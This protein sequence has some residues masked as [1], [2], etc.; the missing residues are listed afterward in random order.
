MATAEA[1]VNVNTNL[2]KQDLSNL[3]IS[4][5]TPLSPEVI[6]RQ[7]TIN[8]G[9]IGHVAHGK[10]TVVKAIS[11]VQTVRFKNELERNITIKLERLSE[12]KIQKLLKSKQ[13]RDAYDLKQRQQLKQ[14]IKRRRQASKSRQQENV[15]AP[16][17][18]TRRSIS[19]VSLSPSHSS[20]YGSVIGPDEHDTLP[21]AIN[22]D[23]NSTVNRRKRCRSSND[24]Q[25][26]HSSSPALK[27]PKKTPK[28][29]YFVEVIERVEVMHNEP[30][31]YVKW[32]GYDNSENT[33]ETFENLADCVQLEDFVDRQ[34]QLYEPYIKK[35]TS[36]LEAELVT[37]TPLD[38]NSINIEKDLDNYESMP[39]SLDLILLA[40]Y[41]AAGSRSQRE[42]QRI[43]ERALRRIQ[44]QRCYYARRKQ[45]QELALFERRMN[46]VEHPA[47]PITV[48]N[49]VDLDSIDANFVYI[50]KNI[51]SDSVPHPEEAVFG[52]NCK[53]DEGDGKTECCATSRC[54]A[55][56][57]GELYAYERTT[58]RLRLPQGSA[59]FECNSRCSCDDSCTNRLVQFGRKHPLELF[60]TSNGRGWGVRT[61]NSLRKGEFVCEYVG[62]IIS[63]DEANE[64]GKAYDDK[65]RTYLFDLDYNTAAESEFTID[66]ANY[67]NV[68]H[69][70]NHS[71]DPNLAVFPCWIEH[72]NMAL[73]HLVFFT[74]RY[75]KAGEE[76]S[77]DYIRADNEAVPYENLS[78]AARVECRCGAPNCRKVLF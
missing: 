17:T 11:G 52:C 51:L 39:L 77:F 4:N 22:Q 20:G 73:P 32:L 24:L 27:R 46:S 21:A 23:D 35:I 18:R 60:K 36:K 10:S 14:L 7:A 6:S 53:H 30:I 33:W 75:I 72:L 28:G 55:R 8:I 19:Q 69:F 67:G 59:I 26:E 76:L 56:L 37:A 9:T 54:C 34:T 71:C 63:S 64:R 43:E 2:Q 48:K 13:Q 16:Y 61:P 78:T 3:E 29:E 31:F 42:R 66:A 15:I 25:N 38:L 5:L 40:Q 50:Q 47:P 49:D 44:M 70:I 68:S 58:R 41:C 62:E 45:L 1:Q 65:G 74:T 12:M 57:A